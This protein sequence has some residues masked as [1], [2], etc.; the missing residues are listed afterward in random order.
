[1]FIKK[2][3]ISGHSA[4]VYTLGFDGEKLYSGSADGFV[5]RWL[6][7]NGV[8][9]QFSINMKNP[10]YALRLLNDHQELVVGLSN[11]DLHFFN[12]ELKVETHFFQQHKKAIF[13]LYENRTQNHLY[14]VDAIG[15]LC[16]WDLTS[17]KL[18]L[19]LPLS[20]GK[21]RRVT[22]N[23][24]GTYLFVASQDGYIRVFETSFFNEIHR[25]YAH[26]DGAN[27]LVLVSDDHLISGGKDAILRKWNWK[28]EQLIKEIPAHHYAIYDVLLMNQGNTLVSASRDKTLKIWDTDLNFIE[29]LD[30]KSGGHFHSVNVLHPISEN[31]MV[32]AGDDKRIVF[33]E[34]EVI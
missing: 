22:C 18:R 5:A 13:H 8:Q 25:F 9:D 33:W 14:S 29:K 30:R 23:P 12:L 6:I 15:M 16:V 2:K 17:K 1:M 19:T 31:E 28:K 10:V 26:H 27:C 21:I 3:E 4:G 11:G 32:S 20:G 34:L 24:D 7:E